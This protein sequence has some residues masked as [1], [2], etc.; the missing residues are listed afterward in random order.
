MILPHYDIVILG[1]GP[2]GLA[3][4]IELKNS[5]YKVLVIEKN[6]VIGPKVCAGGLTNLTSSYPIPKNN[7]RSFYHQKIVVKDKS[8]TVKLTNPIRTLT[9]LELGQFQLQQLQ[10]AP[11]ITTLT[12]TSVKEIKQNELLTNN[13]LSFQFSFLVG[14][15]GSNSIVRKHLNLD[16]HQCVGLYYNIP[17][18]TNDC[19]WYL[20]H[21]TLKT[22]YIWVFPHKEYTNIG[23]YFHP[24]VLNSKKAR[25]VLEDYITTHGFSFNS[26]QLE[27]APVCYNYL[28]HEFE[29]IFL[30]G[31]AAGL[32]SKGTGE[33][34]S[35]A[36]TSGKEIGKKLLDKE[37]K[38]PELIALIRIK[39]RQDKFFKVLET[40]PFLHAFL[41]SI[42][43]KVMQNKKFQAHFGV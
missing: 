32:T 37:Y 16:T 21:K 29:N 12:N 25:Q 13:G 30:I 40:L 42:F 23:V 26:D 19:I 22:G 15:D 1:A 35:Y 7:T 36:L 6:E 9:R 18:I 43:I 8:H 10:V 38:T 14:A 4:A 20:K 2:A 31:D 5:Q 3:C 33:G 34:I 39:K 11:N 41:Y 24:K 28:G 17:V 27:G